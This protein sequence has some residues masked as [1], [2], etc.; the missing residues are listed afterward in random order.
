[1]RPH[2]AGRIILR[3]RFSWGQANKE[4]RTICRGHIPLAP[5]SKTI[6]PNSDCYYSVMS[7]VS[8]IVLGLLFLAITVGI[9]DL[10]WQNAWPFFVILGGLW[11]LAGAANQEP[12]A[13]RSG[14]CCRG[15]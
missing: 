1:M 12:G 10:T 9:F 15:R 6:P 5:S 8:L 2:R 7:G 4:G 14:G 13:R 3:R 11:V